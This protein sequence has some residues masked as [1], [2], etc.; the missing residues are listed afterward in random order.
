MQWEKMRELLGQMIVDLEKASRGNKT[1]AQR[2]RT[3][4][5]LFAKVA[6]EFRKE[7]L[8]AEKGKKKL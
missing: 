1:A 6:K 4:S 5:V 7:S 2:V 8:F 3:S